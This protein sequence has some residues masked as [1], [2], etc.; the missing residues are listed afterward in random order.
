MN[1]LKNF[2]KKIDL[3]DKSIVRLLLL[4]FNVARQIGSY[5][6]KNKISIKDNK[7]EAQVLRNVAK[8][9]KNNDFIKKTFKSIIEYSKMK[10]QKKN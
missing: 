2:R 8:L 1:T 7:R 9:S 4:R 3:I 10:C 6:E 5:K